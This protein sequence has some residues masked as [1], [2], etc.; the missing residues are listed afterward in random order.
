MPKKL[1]QDVVQAVSVTNGADSDAESDEPI[2][3]HSKAANGVAKTN[4]HAK[5]HKKVG[6][7]SKKF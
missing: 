7:S 6:F 4:G 3:V 5:E 2:K 1:K